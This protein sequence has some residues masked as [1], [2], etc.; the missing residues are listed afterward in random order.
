MR[1][2]KAKQIRKHARHV[3]G[4]NAAERDYNIQKYGYHVPSGLDHHGKPRMVLVSGEVFTLKDTCVRAIYKVGKSF[5]KTLPA[6]MRT[7]A[8][9]AR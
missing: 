7:Y 1:G 2:T 3:A 6:P 8:V 9:P 4:A 5:Y